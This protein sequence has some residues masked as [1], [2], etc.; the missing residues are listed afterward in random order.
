ML[1][2]KSILK[3]VVEYLEESGIYYIARIE[4]LGVSLDGTIKIYIP[5]NVVFQSTY[6]QTIHKAIVSISNWWDVVQRQT[7]KNFKKNKK[8]IQLQ[9]P[10]LEDNGDLEFDDPSVQ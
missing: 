4:D 2:I 3:S 8:V 7:V 6:D 9:P 1:N 10:R 5:P